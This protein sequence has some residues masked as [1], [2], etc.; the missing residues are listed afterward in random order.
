MRAGPGTG[1]LT[2]KRRMVKFRQWIRR[3]QGLTGVILR[4][5]S[6]GWD[7]G[8]L[9]LDESEVGPGSEAVVRVV[10]HVEIPFQLLVQGF[11]VVVVGWMLYFWTNSQYICKISITIF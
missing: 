5:G 7:L 3:S 11:T 10:V 6:V 1:D 2:L 4:G 8:L 9:C